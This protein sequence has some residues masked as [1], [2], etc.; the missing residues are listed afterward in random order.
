[1]GAEEERQTSV[2]GCEVHETPLRIGPG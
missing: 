1:M 2:E